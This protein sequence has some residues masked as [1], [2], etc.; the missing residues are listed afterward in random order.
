VK[1][2]QVKY[3]IHQI[4]E[5][6]KFPVSGTVGMPP[7][8]GP[9]HIRFREVWNIHLLSKFSGTSFVHNRKVFSVSYLQGL[10]KVQGPDI[11][12]FLKH[13][14]FINSKYLILFTEFRCRGYKNHRYLRTLEYPAH[15]I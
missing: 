2:Y 14:Y 6:F 9:E 5:L 7:A 3:V 15:N 1:L 8:S 10:G 13:R 11:L 4:E 12:T